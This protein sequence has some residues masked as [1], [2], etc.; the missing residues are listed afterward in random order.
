[1]YS[2]EDLASA[3][4]EGVLTQE[5]ANAFR[6]HVA[7]TRQ[8]PAVDEEYVRLLS[9]FNDIFVVIACALLLVSV[10]WISARWAPWSGGLALSLVAWALAEFFT[11]RRRMALPSIVLLLAFVGGAFAAG[12]SF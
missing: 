11:R 8:L 1:M 12:L 3:V 6:L 2:E 10:G 7:R 9:G 4:K 5:A